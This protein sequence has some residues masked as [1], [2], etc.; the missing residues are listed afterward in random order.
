MARSEGLDSLS[1]DVNSIFLNLWK[2]WQGNP[3]RSFNLEIQFT[4]IITMSS[5]HAI[6]LYKVSSN[7]SY[8]SRCFCHR[9]NKNV[10]LCITHLKSSKRL[11]GVRGFRLTMSSFGRRNDHDLTW[12]YFKIWSTFHSECFKHKIDLCQH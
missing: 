9:V 8:T 2:D 6:P 1:T 10:R 11:E 7:E 5:C 4:S 12:I 3:R